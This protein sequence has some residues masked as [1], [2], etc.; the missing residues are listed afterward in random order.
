MSVSY[1]EKKPPKYIQTVEKALVEVTEEEK[2][3]E[4]YVP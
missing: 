4:D 1:Q 2:A 3:S